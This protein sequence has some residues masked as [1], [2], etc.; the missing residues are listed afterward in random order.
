MPSM[1]GGITIWPYQNGSQ[2]AGGIET[3]PNY[4]RGDRVTSAAFV[5]LSQYVAIM[6]SW[7]SCPSLAAGKPLSGFDLRVSLQG[8]EWRP[9]EAG[10]VS[11]RTTPGDRES[12]RRSVGWQAAGLPLVRNETPQVVTE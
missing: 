10:A 7:R 8:F 1:S 3:P 6:A 2:L 5:N 9:G 4:N 12:G 11:G